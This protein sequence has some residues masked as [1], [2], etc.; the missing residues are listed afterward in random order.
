MPALQSPPGLTSGLEPGPLSL[1]P[2]GR[3]PR[4]QLSA[5]HASLSRP[6]S[7]HP[8]RCLSFLLC[9]V[10]T[11]RLPTTERREGWGRAG[12]SL[13][14]GAGHVV[15]QANAQTVE[16]ITT[17]T[18]G[19]QAPDAG[20]SRARQGRPGFTKGL[21]VPARTSPRPRR[22]PAYS[23]SLPRGRPAGPWL[24]PSDAARPALHRVFQAH[25]TDLETAAP[26]REVTLAG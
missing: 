12:T 10:G 4:T 22:V 13:E 23:P 9:A 21:R 15:G 6:A 2:W 20:D 16:V 1:A 11:R 17:F 8:A 19:S 26:E 7:L 5:E 25:F 3:F 24:P 18:G 14:G